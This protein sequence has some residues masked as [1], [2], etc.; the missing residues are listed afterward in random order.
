MKSVLA[1]CSDSTTIAFGATDPTDQD[2]LIEV[3]IDKCKFALQSK[4]ATP[5]KWMPTWGTI[6]GLNW[7]WATNKCIGYSAYPKAYT[8]NCHPYRFASLNPTV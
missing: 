7:F 8:S 5:T 2:S 4:P 3:G 1:S 6:H